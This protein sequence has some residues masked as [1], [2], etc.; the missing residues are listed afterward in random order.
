MGSVAI[1]A[2]LTMKAIK[3]LNVGNFFFPLYIVKQFYPILSQDSLVP[4]NCKQF[5]VFTIIIRY[6]YQY[7]VWLFTIGSES[8]WSVAVRCHF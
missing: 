2:S 3:T 5:S 1:Y 6:D 4:Y 7:L 8:L